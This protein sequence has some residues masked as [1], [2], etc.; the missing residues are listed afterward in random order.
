MQQ[1]SQFKASLATKGEPVKKEGEEEE[2]EVEEKVEGG[3]KEKRREGGRHMS[4]WLT[5]TQLYTYL[6]WALH[7][8]L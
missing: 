3:Q 7:P 5:N 8:K 6:P 4:S 2:E 1:D